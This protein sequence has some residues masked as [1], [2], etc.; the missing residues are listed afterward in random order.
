MIEKYRYS[1]WKTRSKHLNDVFKDHCYSRWCRHSPHTLACIES[2]LPEIETLLKI[3]LPAAVL[4]AIAVRQIRK[5]SW[6]RRK[7]KKKI[8]T[9]S[10]S[11]RWASGVH[12]FANEAKTEYTF[13]L[14]FDFLSLYSL[15]LFRI[16]AVN[17]LMQVLIF[18]RTTQKPGLLG[19][20]LL[21]NSR[22]RTGT[23]EDFNKMV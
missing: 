14:K 2:S 20:R 11:L 3:L 13:Y 10:A 5:R 16:G 17:R 8:L 21:F 7:S 9:K 18:C 23:P 22:K 19:N 1:P 12:L 15:V 4:K 6:L